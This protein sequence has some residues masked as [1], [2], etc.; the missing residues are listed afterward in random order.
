MSETSYFHNGATAGDA[1][2]APYPAALWSKV[3][4]IIHSSGESGVIPFNQNML[5]PTFS[6][7]GGNHVIVDTGAAVVGGVYYNNSAAVNLFLVANTSAFAR[8][9]TVAIRVNWATHTARLI[10]RTGEPTILFNYPE[11]P[12]D[13]G[14]LYEMPIAYVYLPA[15]SSG[16]A[17]NA[18]HIYDARPFLNTPN[19][20]NTY[21]TENMH[22]NSEFISYH[23][24]YSGLNNY[25]PDMWG[26]ALGTGDTITLSSKFDQQARGYS[27]VVD[28]VSGTAGIWIPYVISNGAITPKVTY[29]ILLQVNSGYVTISDNS[30]TNY[31]QI[32]PTNGPIEFIIRANPLLATYINLLFSGTA[33]SN[34]TIGQITCTYGYIP[35]PTKVQHEHVFHTVGWSNLY[36]KSTGTYQITPAFSGIAGNSPFANWVILSAADSGSAGSNTINASLQSNKGNADQLRVEIGRRT[37]GKRIAVAGIIGHDPATYVTPQEWQE[38][39]LVCTASG[40]LSMTI[41]VY[42]VGLSI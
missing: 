9:D 29:K 42:E 2:N 4:S 19:H 11:L 24:Y 23:L 39:Q 35:A 15:A 21:A 37:N 22:P 40:A 6:A 12:Q 10:Y 20:A 8:V 16:I 14:T 31:A 17:V 7:A 18:L 32:G 33:G 1:I 3:F 5:A 38:V 13:I 25:I 27:V 26:Y 41:Y 28:D 36:T 30:L 34:F